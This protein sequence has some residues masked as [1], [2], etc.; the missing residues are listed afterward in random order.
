[1]TVAVSGGADSMALAVLARD[2][3]RQR[4]GRLSALIVDHDL[5]PESAEEARLTLERLAAQGIPAS[6]L[7]LADLQ[8][9]PALAERAR[10]ARYAVLT[11]AC[12]ATACRH[13]L[14]GHHA[15]DQVETVAM[16]VL[17]G[18]RNDGLAGMSAVRDSRGVRLLRPLLSVHPTRLRALLS[19]N[20][21][22]WVEDP[23][24][25]DMRALRPRLRRGLSGM[26]WDALLPAIT[27]AGERR[28]REEIAVAACLADCV[29]LYPEGFALAGADRLLP[30]ALSALITAVAG[31]PYPPDPD[32][33]AGLAAHLTAATLHGVRIMPAGR[34]GPGW[35]IVREE[36]CIQLSIRAG[37]ESLWDERFV[38]RAGD[39]PLPAD[40]T[41]GKLG[42]DAARLRHLTRLPSV[43]LRTLPAIRFGKKLAA[44]P[45]LSYVDEGNPLQM[46]VTFAPPRPVKAAL[47]VPAASAYVGLATSPGASLGDGLGCDS[48]S[49]GERS[50]GVGMQPCTPRTM[51]QGAPSGAPSQNFPWCAY[52]VEDASKVI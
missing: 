39:A 19:E 10:D 37:S 43:V 12:R 28:V 41:I 40:A 33:V 15:G 13:L 44:V 6:I 16:R 45:H 46:T 30:G 22:T 4:H 26:S 38:L 5:R 51:Y 24:N 50:G 7:T 52:P 47:F 36:A 48:P 27:E 14:L 42:D 34:L 49:F 11:A 9:G 31:A 35:L 21:I 25:R 29:T 23:S 1:M 20:G 32:I 3:V 8:R 18:S 2:W 17:R